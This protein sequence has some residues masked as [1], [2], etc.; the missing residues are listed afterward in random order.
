MVGKHC[1]NCKYYMW[2]SCLHNESSNC[3]HS[4]LWTPIGVGDYDISMFNLPLDIK[5]LLEIGI[6]TEEE[7]INS[8]K[9]R[10]VDRLTG[11]ELVDGHTH[12]I[13]LTTDMEA[14]MQKLAEYEDAEQHGKLIFLDDDIDYDF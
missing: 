11:Y 5:G 13:P 9:H 1:Y 10:T 3:N 6:Y 7:L 8:I 2:G 4:E 14:I 12:A